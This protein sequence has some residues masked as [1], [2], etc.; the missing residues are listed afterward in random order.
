[1][2]S[3]HLLGTAEVAEFLS[4]SRQRVTQLRSTYP[5]FPQP[6]VELAAGNV[7]ARTAIEGWV[8]AHPERRGG[9]RN[10]VPDRDSPAT[11]QV[12]ADAE[13]EARS[14]GHSVYGSAH[15]VFGVV[16]LGQGP[17]SETLK[18]AGLGVADAREW[19][20]SRL[21]AGRDQRAWLIRS[22]ELLAAMERAQAGA[23]AL[24]SPRL[25]PEHLLIG[26]LRQGCDGRKLI[27]DLGLH[28]PQVLARLM[29]TLHAA[30]SEAMWSIGPEA[31]KAGSSPLG[32]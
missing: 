2:V 6:E 15:V 30:G 31:T 16:R 12:M 3:H 7:W 32:S 29:E 26:A 20:R 4:V 10:V 11:K 1:M 21:P 17:A 18:A 13:N 5:D 14:L 9:R 22:D 28:P 27:A 24:G 8:A 23:F 25:E 19:L